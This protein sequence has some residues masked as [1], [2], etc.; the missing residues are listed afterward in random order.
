VSPRFDRRVGFAEGTSSVPFDQLAMVHRGEI[1]VPREPS[2]AIRAGSAVLGAGPVT[3]TV[4]VG[5]ISVDAR[6]ATNPRAVGQAVMDA[7]A[8]GLRQET[9]RLPVGTR[10]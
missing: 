9:A 7:V 3:T 2:E 6:G 5:P 8:E 1:I 4:T 10:S